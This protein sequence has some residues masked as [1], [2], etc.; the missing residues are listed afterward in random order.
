MIYRFFI[1]VLVCS[2]SQHIFCQEALDTST[3]AKISEK[4]FDAVSKKANTLQQN[5]D[6]KSQRVLDRMQKQEVKLQKKLAKIDSLATH[7]IFSNSNSILCQNKH[8]LH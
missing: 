8:L 5:L 6:K 7:N 3:S 2:I 1:T 4:Y